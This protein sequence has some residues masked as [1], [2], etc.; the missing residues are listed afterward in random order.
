MPDQPKTVEFIWK[1]SLCYHSCVLSISV[2]R[3][4]NAQIVSGGRMIR[5]CS[6]QLN[7]LLMVSNIL[8]LLLMFDHG[9][10]CLKN[11]QVKV[12]PG[13]KN[14]SVAV[15]ILYLLLRV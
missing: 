10:Q 13:A 7:L 4:S 2:C 15:E 9:F 11:L 5:N 8:N 14:T 3:E 12:L 6:P 1:R